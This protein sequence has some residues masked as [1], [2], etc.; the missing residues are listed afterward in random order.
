ML[1]N[2]FWMLFLGNENVQELPFPAFM[3]VAGQ[4]LDMSSVLY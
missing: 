1:T 4:L 3:S 2:L